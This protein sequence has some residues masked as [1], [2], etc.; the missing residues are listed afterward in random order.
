MIANAVQIGEIPAPAKRLVLSM[1]RLCLHPSRA[2]HEFNFV[3]L[4][5][6]AIEW[7]SP[8]SNNLDFVEF[9]VHVPLRPPALPASARAQATQASIKLNMYLLRAMIVL[10]VNEAHLVNPVMLYTL[11][12]TR[13][14]L[15]A[16][17]YTQCKRV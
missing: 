3:S 4:R 16:T 14:T 12:A 2:D 6:G 5:P 17:R 7:H 9:I 11:Y 13:Y 15:H 1:S 10:V 8:H